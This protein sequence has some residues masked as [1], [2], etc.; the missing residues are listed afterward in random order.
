MKDRPGLIPETGTAPPPELEE[1][2][3]IKK[4]AQLCGVRSDTVR[5]WIRDGRL[6]GV[7]LPT[8]HLR[9]RRSVLMRF[10]NSRYGAGGE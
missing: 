8:G 5:G 2:Y 9:V 10:L 4:V 6:E 7:R 1:H 3:T